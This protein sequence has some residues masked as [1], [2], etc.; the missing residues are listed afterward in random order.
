MSC[1]HDLALGLCKVCYPQSGTVDPGGEPAEPN[2]EGPGAVPYVA[3][4]PAFQYAKRAYKRINDELIAIG[5]RQ[6]DALCRLQELCIHP[7]VV[8]DEDIVGYVCP[9]CDSWG[10]DDSEL[11]RLYREQNP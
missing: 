5:V 1:R 4:H 8:F 2:L 9:D 3:N 11:A 7:R 10:D 6:Y